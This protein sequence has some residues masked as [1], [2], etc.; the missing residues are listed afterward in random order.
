MKANT[1][2]RQRTTAAVPPCRH[3][4]GVECSTPLKCSGCGW[5]PAVAA[6]RSA[7]I[8]KARQKPETKYWT[9][10]FPEVHKHG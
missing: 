3:N 1:Q 4:I 9:Y 10:D 2:Y 6:E 8:R 7:L 5:N